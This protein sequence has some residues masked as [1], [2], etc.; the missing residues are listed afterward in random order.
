M[1]IVAKSLENLGMQTR[2]MNPKL[3]GVEKLTDATAEIII[4]PA[5][6]DAENTDE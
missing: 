3:R 6:A 1:S 2:A 4:G 5:L